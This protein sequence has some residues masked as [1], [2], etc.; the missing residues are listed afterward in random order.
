MSRQTEGYEARGEHRQTQPR[1]EPGGAGAGDALRGQ[2]RTMSFDDQVQ[3]LTPGAD[4]DGAPATRGGSLD[5]TSVERWVQT[6]LNVVLGAGLAVDGRLAGPTRAAVRTFQRK[7]PQ[8][9]GTRLAVDGVAGPRTIGALEGATGSSAPTAQEPSRAPGADSQKDDTGSEGPAQ[10][11][12]AVEEEIP[13]GVVEQQVQGEV[14]RLASQPAPEAARVDTSQAYEEAKAWTMARKGA[15]DTDRAIATK[16]K[17]KESWAEKRKKFDAYQTQEPK[18]GRAPKDPGDLETFITANWFRTY[19]LRWCYQFAAKVSEFLDGRKA[20]GLMGLVARTREAAG[21]GEADKVKG[22]T[23]LHRGKTLQ[24]AGAD[25]VAS[26]R[27]APGT[28]FHVKV[29]WEGDN[30]YEFKDDFHHWMVY[31]GQ[32]KFSDTLTGKDKAGAAMDTTLRN[33]VKGSFRHPDYA[34]MH[35][36]PK[37][38]SIVNGKPRPHANL[39]PLVSAEYDPRQSVSKKE[40]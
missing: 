24:Q 7:A 16:K 29:H 15:L 8:L 17:L 34:F 31:A 23:T 21:K 32:G 30:P 3:R 28:S 11:A 2:L 14:A 20:T 19:W 37:Y 35:A 33:W 13:D 1:I 22:R 27:L 4:A 9:A 6:A 5:E 25:E 40:G 10:G 18:K 39:Q 12:P 38:A 26:P 36:D